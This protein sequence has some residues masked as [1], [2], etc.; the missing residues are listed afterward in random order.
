MKDN[1]EVHDL[2]KLPD[3]LIIKSQSI[4]IG[5][6]TS[7]LNEYEDRDKLLE[8]APE[9]IKQIHQLLSSNFELKHK[10]ACKTHELSE[11]KG[12]VSIISIE[13]LSKLKSECHR[14]HQKVGSL[15]RKIV[16]MEKQLLSKL[17]K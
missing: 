5:K 1:T 16:V 9:H 6:L 14:Y 11:L 17:I 12:Y 3:D 8:K 2:E 10:L 13:D 4:E 7:Q 15:E